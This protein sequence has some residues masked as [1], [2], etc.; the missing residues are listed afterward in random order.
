MQEGEDG[1]EQPVYY[2][3]RALR[4]AETLTQK[5]NTLVYL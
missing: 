3:S 5:L 4:D 1:I 2:M